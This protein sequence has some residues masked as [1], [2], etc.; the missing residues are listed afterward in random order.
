MRTVQMFVCEIC[1]TPHPTRAKATACARHCKAVQAK[2]LRMADAARRATERMNA[3]RLLSTSPEDFLRRLEAWA[4][5]E[6]KVTVDLWF[7][8]ALVVR[9]LISNSHACMPVRLESG[10]P[11]YAWSL[12]T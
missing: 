2:E 5:A 11:R 3:P 4:L 7:S 8:R 1:E 10:T 9:E 6:K 12:R